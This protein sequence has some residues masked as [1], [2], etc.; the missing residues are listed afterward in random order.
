MIKVKELRIGNF[1][2][3]DEGVLSKVTGF[4]P[5]E[6]SVRCDEEEGCHILVDC[7]HANGSRRTGRETDSPECNPIPLTPEWL[8]RC[9]LEYKEPH[10]IK[11][12]LSISKN[13]YRDGS[14]SYNGFVLRHKFEDCMQVLVIN[15]VH[16]LQNL[17][18]ALTGE[19][20]TINF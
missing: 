13:F 20:L 15:Y 4:A 10:Y 8:E 3:D 6:H 12:P 7:Y 19:E 5:F 2:S 14:G 17:Y 16:Q 9:G 1:I 18:F 11:R